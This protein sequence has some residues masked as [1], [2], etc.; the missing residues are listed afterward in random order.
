MIDSSSRPAG[1]W[2]LAWR[3]LV[4]H[5]TAMIGLAVITM[6]ALVAILAPWLAPYDY[7]RQFDDRVS[8][9]PSAQHWLGTDDS[10]RDVLSRVIYGAQIS[11][12]VGLVATAVSLAI[13]V[14]IGAVA[15]YAGGWLDSVLMRVTDSFFAFPG[16]LLAIGIT[17]VFDT[18]SI[19]VVF[20]A[21]GLVGW[22]GIARVVRSQ[23]LTVRETQYVTA[24]EACG[25]GSARIILRHIIPNCLGPIV[26]LGTFRVAATILIE[27][28]LSFLGL[29]V[30]P[31]HPSWGSMLA[32]A[33]GLYTEFPWMCYFPGGAIVITVLSLNLLGDGVR[34]ALDPRI[35][36]PR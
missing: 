20:L 16:L 34:D 29:G 7:A 8:Q 4:R 27:A 12:T 15:A 26:V 3:R 11:L 22:P 33:R 6:L 31:P 19:F 13:A 25:A 24:A 35:K 28:G 18:P 36:T 23:V 30:Q 14:V 9:A 5:R 2:R 17:A 1:P 21:L 10:G 32:D